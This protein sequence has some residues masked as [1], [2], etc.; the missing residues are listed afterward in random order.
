LELLHVDEA[1]IVVNKPAGLLSAAGRRDE[2]HIPAELRRLPLFAADEP[3][4]LVHRLDRDAT[5]VIVYARTLEAQQ[6]IVRQFEQR[7]VEKVY[8]ALV[9]GYVEGDGE[10]NRPLDF[11]KRT[12]L[13][14]V[15]ARG[16]ASV[17]RYTVV[18]R[19]PGHTLLEC[20]PLT[21]RQHQIRVHLASIGH[22][23]AI[24]PLYGSA[25]PLLLSGYKTGYRASGRHKERPLINRLT[26]HALRISFVH[27]QTSEPVTYEAPLPKDLRVTIAQLARL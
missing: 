11:D 4:R 12:G 25:A 6:L 15:R 14:T 13:V 20:R 7:A 2:P 19:V 21:G 24:D 9:A 5:G 18:Q 27:P 17:T 22:P 16:K 10:I 3:I 8:I 1:L 23:L 26:L